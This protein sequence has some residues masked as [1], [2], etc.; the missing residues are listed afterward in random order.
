MKASEIRLNDEFS[1]RNLIAAKGW[2][3]R[4]IKTQ[5]GQISN[6][7]NVFLSPEENLIAHQYADEILTKLLCNATG[8]KTGKVCWYAHKEPDD[9]F[10]AMGPKDK[11]MFIA[12][13]AEEGI[14]ITINA[15][16]RILKAKI[17]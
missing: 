11:E 1:P 3:L 15:E 10:E 14:E 5:I 9:R 16:E 2:V 7:G 4:L 13:L 17:L 8:N 6:S 12:L